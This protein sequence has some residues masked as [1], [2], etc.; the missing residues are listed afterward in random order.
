MKG[1]ANF[2]ILLLGLLSL[3]SCSNKKEE[4]LLMNMLKEIN[5]YV[6]EKD[7]NAA[8]NFLIPI[9]ENIIVFKSYSII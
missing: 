5:K 7:E 2:F 9:I 1:I 4:N 8:E 6:K 3:L